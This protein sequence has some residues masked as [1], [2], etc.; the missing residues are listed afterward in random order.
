V[1]AH[2]DD[3]VDLA[4]K[5][6]EDS[7]APPALRRDALQVVLLMQSRADSRKPAIDALSHSEAGIRNL[8]LSYLVHGRSK[9]GYLRDDLVY[10]NLYTDALMQEMMMMSGRGEAPAAL[11]APRG[12]KP[13]MLRPLLRDPDPR[14]VAYAGYL[15]ALLG[16][17]EGLE[18]LLRYWRDHAR[19]DDSWRRLAYVAVAACADDAHVRTLE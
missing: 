2:P 9:L 18:P 13:E 15:L 12:M 6:A 7:K 17:T 5:L 3:L 14:S 4:R 19:T 10:L 16:E 8:A 11:E 1:T